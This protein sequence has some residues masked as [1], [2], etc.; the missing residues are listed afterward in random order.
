[1]HFGLALE[2][3]D[4]DLWNID[5]LGTHLDLLDTD[6]PSKYFVSLHSVFKTS[7]R[8]VFKTSWRHVFKTPSVQQFF[9]F[10][11]VFKTSSRRL[12]RRKIVMLKTCWRRLQDQQMFAGLVLYVLLDL[13]LLLLLILVI[14]FGTLLIVL[15]NKSVIFLYSILYYI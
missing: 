10:Q 4:I 5:L 14:H 6:I 1:M 3:S 2:L 12:G 11:D 13:L 15:R 8:Y 7:S 9:V